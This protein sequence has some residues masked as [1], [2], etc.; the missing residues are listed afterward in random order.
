MVA[1]GY[2]IEGRSIPKEG[3]LLH[4]LTTIARQG[5]ILLEVMVGKE[6]MLFPVVPQGCAVA[7]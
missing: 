2:R 6:E 1:K 3:Q 5:A 4:A 7:E